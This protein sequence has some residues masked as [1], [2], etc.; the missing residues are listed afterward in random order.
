M[1]WSSLNATNSF[2]SPMFFSF[3]LCCNKT[4]LSISEIIVTIKRWEL[5]LFA[6]GTENYMHLLAGMNT[7]RY[8]KY[9]NFNLKNSKTLK[10]KHRQPKKLVNAFRNFYVSYVLLPFK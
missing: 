9:L 1:Q 8:C 10:K 7:G 4:K 3:M 6:F 5:V 2:I